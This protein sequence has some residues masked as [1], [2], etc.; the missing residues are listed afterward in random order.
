MTLSYIQI[1]GVSARQSSPTQNRDVRVIPYSKML[2]PQ[3][4]CR[5]FVIVRIPLGIEQLNDG[6]DRSYGHHDQMG[7]TIP[8]DP[9]EK[10]AEMS[11]QLGRECVSVTGAG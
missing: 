6:R 9:D 7:Q 4:P 10:L 11:G 5:P 3:G 1:D 8:M 2:H